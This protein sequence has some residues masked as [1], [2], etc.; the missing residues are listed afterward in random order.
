MGLVVLDSMDVL[1]SV[2]VLLVELCDVFNE[3]CFFVVWGNCG[4]IVV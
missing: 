2:V 4:V 3:I 1:K